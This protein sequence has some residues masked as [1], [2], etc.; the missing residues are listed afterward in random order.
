M[1]PLLDFSG[2]LF[3]KRLDSIH[4][5]FITAARALNDLV[6]EKLR[7]LAEYERE[8]ERGMDP[9]EHRDADGFLIWSQDQLLE[10]RISDAEEALQSVHKSTV[11]AAYHAWEDA[12]RRFTKIGNRGDHAYLVEALAQH[13]VTAHEDLEWI[14]LLVNTLKHGNPVKGRKLHSLRPDLF[15]RSLG[16]Q[17]EHVD[18]PGAIML[19]L[20]KVELVI[21][22]LGRSGPPADPWS[23]KGNP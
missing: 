2:Y 4:Q 5:A 18:W 12:T 15:R 10:V 17:A 8:V 14:V 21:E 1:V 9:I 23:H 13:G 7:D 16:T 19:S 20:E 22:R 6:E 3:A 11:M